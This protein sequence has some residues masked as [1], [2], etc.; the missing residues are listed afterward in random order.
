MKKIFSPLLCVISAS[1]LLLTSC[2]GIFDDIYDV[3]TPTEGSF[4]VDASSWKTW[5][6]I[7]LPAVCDS[8]RRN[9]AFDASA[10]ITTVAIPTTAEGDMETVNGHQKCGQYTYWYDVFGEGI[11]KSE[12]RSFVPTAAQPDPEHW[13][14]AFHRDNV[15]TN[16]CGVYETHYTSFDEL[17]PS[18]TFRD[19]TFTPDEWSENDVWDDQSTLMKCLVPSQGIM[20]NKVLSSWLVMSLPPIPP[21]FAHNDH[22]F[23][24]R[25]KDGTYGALRLANYVSPQGVKCNLTI[26]YKYPL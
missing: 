11:T 3:P 14:I 1:L 7:D 15:R 21:S 16:G 26:E 24:L 6:Y 13:T 22:V 9:P 23:I 12:F 25:L 2:N 10:S 8:L 19:L 20:I 18:D 17:P 5:S 4:H